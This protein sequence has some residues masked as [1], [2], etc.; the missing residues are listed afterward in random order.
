MLWSSWAKKKGIDIIILIL[1]KDTRRFELVKETL[2]NKSTV[3][4]A[5]EPITEVAR[6]KRLRTQ[7]YAGLCNSS[8]TVITDLSAPLSTFGVMDKDVLV[9]LPGEC[10]STEFLELARKILMDKKVLQLV[11]TCEL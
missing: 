4:N 2:Q 10:P 7:K 1:D 11:R 3:S 5:L 9:A 8:G 6:D